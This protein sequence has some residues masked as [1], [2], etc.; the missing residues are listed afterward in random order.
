MQAFKKQTRFFKRTFLAG[1]LNGHQ[2]L[3]DRQDGSKTIHDRAHYAPGKPLCI[4]R[5]INEYFYFLRLTK[6]RPKAVIQWD[7]AV[8]IM[9]LGAS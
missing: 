1:D 8:Y 3:V 2:N 6:N 7:Q 4:L 9:R 5:Q